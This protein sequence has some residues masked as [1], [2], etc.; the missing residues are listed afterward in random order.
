MFR[1]NVTRDNAP[2][3]VY[4]FMPMLVCWVFASCVGMLLCDGVLGRGAKAAENGCVL[5]VHSPSYP[6]EKT[7]WI[8]SPAVRSPMLPYTQNARP[9]HGRVGIQG[10]PSNTCLYIGTIIYLTTSFPLVFPISSSS[11]S[12]TPLCIDLSMQNVHSSPKQKSKHGQIP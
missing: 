11:L 4:F 9:L 7:A 10:F 6:C 5:M 2:S 3:N 1:G 8:P 12:S